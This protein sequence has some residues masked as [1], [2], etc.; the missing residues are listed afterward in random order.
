MILEQWQNNIL[1][2]SETQVVGRAQTS[3]SVTFFITDLAGTETGSPWPE[4][5][6]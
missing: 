3:A 2:H 6:D 4:A 1:T 5:A